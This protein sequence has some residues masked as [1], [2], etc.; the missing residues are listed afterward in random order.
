MTDIQTRLRGFSVHSTLQE[1]QLPLLLFSVV[2]SCEWQIWGI[3]AACKFAQDT[4]LPDI[5]HSLK[6]SCIDIASSV[7]LRSSSILKHSSMIT[8]STHHTNLV[9]MTI[10]STHKLQRSKL[11]LTLSKFK[12][13]MWVL[14]S[15]RVL[16]FLEL[17]DD[18]IFPKAHYSSVRWPH[19]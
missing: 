3:V 9:S 2:M 13:M 1:L 4:L 18:L 16:I 17:I 7:I 8:K 6:M 5:Q 11:K 14:P 19:R 12:V 15:L 10:L